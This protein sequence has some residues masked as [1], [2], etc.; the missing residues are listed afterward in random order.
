MI[1][2]KTLREKKNILVASIF[3]YPTKFSKWL[4]FRVIQTQ[5]CEVKTSTLYHTIPHN[6]LSRNTTQL[7]ITQY[8]TTLYHA[9]PH[10]SLPRNTTQLFTTQSRLLT[11]P[12]RTLENIVGK[13]ENAGNQHFLLF[14]QCFLPSQ[15]QISIL[16][17][18]FFVVC[19]CFDFYGDIFLPR[20]KTNFP[21]NNIEIHV[22]KCF[23][24]NKSRYF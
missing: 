9:I 12:L 14:S 2:S 16:E 15:R 24:I 17:P 1:G 21:G 19:K 13:G 11:T 6:S 7:F 18:H 10:K 23:T 3:P 5:F 20:D 22:A 8:H 4:F